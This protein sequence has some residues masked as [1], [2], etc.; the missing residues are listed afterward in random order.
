ME[1]LFKVSWEFA[2]PN[3]TQSWYFPFGISYCS[4]FEHSFMVSLNRVWECFLLINNLEKMFLSFSAIPSPRWLGKIPDVNRPRPNQSNLGQF[5]FCQI[6]NQIFLSTEKNNFS[7]QRRLD[8]KKLFSRFVFSFFGFFER[9]RQIH[10]G[11]GL[12]NTFFWIFVTESCHREFNIVTRDPRTVRASHGY[13]DERIFWNLLV[14]DGNCHPMA[15]AILWGL[16]GET[17][18]F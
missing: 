1:V 17:K 15:F 7:S 18:P 5:Q 8:K 6:W 14:F 16:G 2:C 11:H 9:E 12:R 3:L 13:W 10:F 4:K